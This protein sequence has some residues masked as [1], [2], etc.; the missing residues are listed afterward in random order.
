VEEAKKRGVE[1]IYGYYYPTA[2]N[3]MVKELYAHFG[4]DKQSEDEAGNTVWKLE[5][6]DYSKRCHV[7][8]INE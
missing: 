6:A 8:A 2:K 7:I 4:F 3:K 1:Q 5:T